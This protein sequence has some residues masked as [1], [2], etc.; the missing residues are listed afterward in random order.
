VFATSLNYRLRFPTKIVYAFLIFL[1]RATRY[2]HL[3]LLVMVCD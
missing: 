2:T 1:K 3:S